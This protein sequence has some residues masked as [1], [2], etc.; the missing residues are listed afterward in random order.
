MIIA[1]VK[2]TATPLDLR[3]KRT[4]L[5]VDTALTALQLSNY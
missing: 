2:I 1:M 5:I 3:E 4:F